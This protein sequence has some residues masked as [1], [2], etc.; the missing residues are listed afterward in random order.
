VTFAIVN[1]L[2]LA[3]RRRAEDEAGALRAK[4][5]LVAPDDMNEVLAR[6]RQYMR[7]AI[8]TLF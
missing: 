4:F 1:P 5:V 7:G 6:Y 8:D 2:D 3:A